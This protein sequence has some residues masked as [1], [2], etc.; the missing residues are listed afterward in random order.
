MAGDDVRQWQGRIRER[1]WNITVDGVYGP[2][3]EYVCRA[4][5]E[6]KGLDVDGVIG[7]ATWR[8]TWESPI[9]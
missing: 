8:A 1:G 6:D 4:F 7:P 5:Q 9:T 2:R 3:S